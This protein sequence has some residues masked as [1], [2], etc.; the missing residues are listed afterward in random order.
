[1]NQP[2]CPHCGFDLVQDA[3][4][5]L[6]DFAMMSSISPLQWQG[7][8]IKLTAAERNLMWTLMKAAPRPVRFDVILDRIGSESEG[9]VI[10]VYMSR[11]RKKLRD[12]G[13]PVP[14]D[15]LKANNG[16]RALYWKLKP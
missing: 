1:V 15:S 13:A 12:L 9:N 8:S 14:F 5:L 11:I 2:F 4:I 6:G 10:D 16:Y 3:P 7:H